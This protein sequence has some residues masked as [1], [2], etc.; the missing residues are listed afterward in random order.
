MQSSSVAGLNVSALRASELHKRKESFLQ[1]LVSS[2]KYSILAERVGKVVK[3]VVV[4]KC[5][6]EKMGAS[7]TKVALQKI[8]T[9]F[10]TPPILLFQF[11]LAL[12]YKPLLSVSRSLESA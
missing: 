7:M 12:H 9:L 1:E 4:D 2:G 8:E 6:K 11:E 10:A 3:A 5:R